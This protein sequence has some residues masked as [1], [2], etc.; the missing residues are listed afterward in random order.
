MTA[1]N[2]LA[3]FRSLW[4]SE[5][6]TSVTDEIAKPFTI[7][8]AAE[9]TGVSSKTI[10]R[11]QHPIMNDAKH[12]LRPHF[13]PSAKQVREFKKNKHPF[14]IRFSEAAYREL[15]VWIDREG[16]PRRS[17]SAAAS[18]SQAEDQKDLRIKYLEEKLDEERNH[19]RQMQARQ[20]EVQ[21]EFNVLMKMLTE[22][23]DVLPS[24]RPQEESD[25]QVVDA[26]VLPSQAEEG[27]ESGVVE[28]TIQQARPEKRIPWWK[29]GPRIN[30]Q[31]SAR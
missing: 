26:I 11:W 29:R 6:M 24:A 15:E 9:R 12:P 16:K 22:K 30:V 1:E 8:I 20:M 18:S 23:L 27:S 19:S 7:R 2:Q 10:R 21:T 31:F 13:S 25:S 14:T 5:C 3:R 28:A 17:A 4:Q